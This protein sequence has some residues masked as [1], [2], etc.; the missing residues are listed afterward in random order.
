[1][2]TTTRVVT[3]TFAA[4]SLAAAGAVLAHPGAG[5]GAGYGMGYG[6]GHGMGYGAGY[7]MQGRADAGPGAWGGM[8]GRAGMGPGMWGGM[9]GPESAGVTAARLADLKAEIKITA[10][11]E[12]PWQA[13][14]DLIQQQTVARTALHTQMHEQMHAQTP[15]PKFDF[16]A[17]RDAMF[18]LNEG[19]YT[20][21]AAALKDLQA[22]LSPEQR[23]TADQ[24]LGFGPGHHMAARGWGR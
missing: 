7:G 8:H 3:A 10:A 5:E 2:R 20:A 24:L 19:Q 1:M 6:M 4:L 9:N 16:A 15:D 18:K 11:Q 21:R 14:V 12:G 22:V 13:Y 17:T 23:V